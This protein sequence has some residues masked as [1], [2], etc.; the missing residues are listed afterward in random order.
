[1]ASFTIACSQHGNTICSDDLMTIQAEQLHDVC[2]R[3]NYIA[4]V[5][6]QTC[7]M[8]ARFPYVFFCNL[9]ARLHIVTN[10]NKSLSMNDITTVINLLASISEDMW[11]YKVWLETLSI[12]QLY[13]LN[14]HDRKKNTKQKKKYILRGSNPRE[15]TA[16]RGLNPTP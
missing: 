16:H 1:M 9:N 8:H 5:K 4:F 12:E 14:V 2:V 11:N 7:C 13:A 3:D 15:L 6:S 10:K